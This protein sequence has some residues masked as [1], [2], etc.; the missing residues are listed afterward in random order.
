MRFACPIV[1]RTRVVVPS[2]AYLTVLRSLDTIVYMCGSHASWT[3]DCCMDANYAYLAYSTIYAYSYGCIDFI[4]M[5]VI[6]IY[7]LQ[8]TRLFWPN[9]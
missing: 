3:Y 8:L 2:L 7:L 4:Y 9:T 1:L 5:I 6:V